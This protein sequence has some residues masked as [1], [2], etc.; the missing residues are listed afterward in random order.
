MS[1]QSGPEAP[2]SPQ[3]GDV[4][5]PD[6]ERV[7]RVPGSRR[8]VLPPMPGTDPTP[9]ATRE[10]VLAAEDSDRSW[11]G[12]SAA[13]PPAAGPNDAQLLQDVPPHWG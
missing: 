13:R 4:R 7:R 2:E 11:G 8:A 12:P 5:T 3:P 9:Q 10:A 6:A 1:N